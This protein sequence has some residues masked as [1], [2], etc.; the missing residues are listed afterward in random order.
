MSACL[1]LVQ[2]GYCTTI[3]T[4]TDTIEIETETNT[5][6]EQGWPFEKERQQKS[7]KLYCAA[8]HPVSGRVGTVGVFCM[9][10]GNNLRED[11]T[12]AN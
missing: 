9:V 4:E 2:Q 3:E 7:S 11:S 12:W 8:F 1:S 10:S 6:Q 5:W